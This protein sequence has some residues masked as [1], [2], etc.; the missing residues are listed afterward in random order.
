MKLL[1][2]AVGFLLLIIL[3]MIQVAAS[4]AVVPSGAT[5]DFYQVG[6]GL[7]YTN[8]VQ[9]PPARLLPLFGLDLGPPCT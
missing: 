4:A 8:L 3:L 9:G 7:P 1:G 6:L 5:P 2:M